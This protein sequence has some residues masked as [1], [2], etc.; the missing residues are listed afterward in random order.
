M[1]ESSPVPQKQS[2]TSP[3]I[4]KGIVAAAVTPVSPDMTVD[5]P[6]LIQH[7]KWLLANGCDMVSLFGTSGEGPS[8]PLF[9]RLEATGRVIRSGVPASRLIPAVMT[10]GIQDARDLLTGYAALGCRAVLIMPPFFFE[11]SD[12]GVM[13]FFEQT[14]GAVETSIPF[15]LY[16]YPA[17]SGF[18]FSGDLIA[19]LSKRFGDQLIGIKDS[20]GDR[21]HSL[22]LISRF[23]QLSVFTG[24]DTDLCTVVAAGGAGIIGG[25][26]NANA[27]LLRAR[28]AAPPDQ[29]EALDN[30][31]Q[32]VFAA[33][34]EI[35]GPMPLRMMVARVHNDA[36][37]LHPM[38][39]LIPADRFAQA[40]LVAKIEAAG[41]AFPVIQTP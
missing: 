19:R 24:T 6:R 17:I 13:A 33:I 10:T 15:L 31:I 32:Q 18:A 30:T 9:E 20:S 1:A 22:A 35:G 27:A 25:A 23:P 39:P 38:P 34:V 2:K 8:F 26:P 37:W 7:V 36:A 40:A 16:H 3:P 41:Y 4:L 29:A 28:L 11:G 12:E 5:H 21:A 14:V